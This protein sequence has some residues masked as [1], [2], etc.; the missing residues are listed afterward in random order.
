LQVVPALRHIYVVYLVPLTVK[1]PILIFV[2]GVSAWIRPV[3]LFV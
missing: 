1:P 3:E 2:N